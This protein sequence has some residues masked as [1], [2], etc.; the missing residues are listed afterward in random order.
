MPTL[1]ALQSRLGGHNFSV[2][3]ISID[4]MGIE[5][6]RRFCSEIGIRNLPLYWGDDV[7]VQFAFG[8]FGL[9]TTLLVDRVGR[10][11]GR[12]VG[13]IRWDSDDAVSQITGIIAEN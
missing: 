1:D 13:P 9:P 7:R 3:P 4:R 6:A 10:E 5:A 8:V 12:V 11:R 2:V